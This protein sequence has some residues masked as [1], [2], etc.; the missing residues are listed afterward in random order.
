[1]KTCH[2][3]RFPEKLTFTSPQLDYRIGIN[4]FRNDRIDE[5]HQT[6]G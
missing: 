2:N 3:S 6:S 1:M 4:L 5:S